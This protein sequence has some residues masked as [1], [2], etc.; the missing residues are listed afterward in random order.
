MSGARFEL[1]RLTTVVLKT[2]PLDHSGIHADKNDRPLQDS[3]LR[4]NFPIDFESIALTAR[5]SGHESHPPI[6]FE[7]RQAYINYTEELHDET[8]WHF[9]ED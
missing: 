5:P 7:E 9:A 3:N 1:A 2:T 4:G 6:S 8:P